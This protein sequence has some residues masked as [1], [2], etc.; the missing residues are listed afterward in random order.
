MNT[1]SSAAPRYF[2]V[3]PAAGSGQR[4]ASERPKQYLEINGRTLLQHTLERLGS[5]ACFERIVLVLSPQDAWWPV[6][7]QQLPSSIR[8]KLTVAT[9]GS[10]RADSVANGLQ[11]LQ[12]VAQ[13]QD[14]ILVHDVVRPCIHHSDVE[15]LITAVKDE[16]AG[17]LLATPVRDTLKRSSDLQVVEQT[18]D[19]RNL[20]CAATPQMFRYRLLLESLQKVTAAGRTVTDEAEAVEACGHPVKLVQGRTDNLKVT[21]PQDLQLAALILRAQ[22]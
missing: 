13:R 12:G 16:V 1:T 19:R 5:M 7:E 4:M 9:G 11:A 14:W 17:G 21:Y 10:Q 8:Q 6:I 3:L 18:V 20:W 22:S 2:L 15:L